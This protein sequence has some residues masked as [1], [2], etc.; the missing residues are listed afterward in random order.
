[1]RKDR[2]DQTFLYTSTRQNHNFVAGRR[3]I[4]EKESL[5]RKRWGYIL[6]DELEH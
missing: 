5:M 3:E 6:T 1:M 2:G 4:E